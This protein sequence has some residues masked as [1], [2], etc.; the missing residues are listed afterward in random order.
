MVKQ[1][2]GPPLSA[3]IKQ[4]I[5]AFIRTEVSKETSVTFLYTHCT[6]H[7]LSKKVGAITAT[8]ALMRVEELADSMFPPW[9]LVWQPG[10]FPQVCTL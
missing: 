7:K 3:H 2:R 9:N 1:T 10:D 5:V 6:Y 8:G 4:I